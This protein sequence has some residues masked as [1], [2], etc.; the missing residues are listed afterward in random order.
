MI[1]EWIHLYAYTLHIYLYP[2]THTHTHLHINTHIDMC[3]YITSSYVT[4][5]VNL[6]RQ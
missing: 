6:Y 5:Y 2:Y 1:F 3:I 4:I